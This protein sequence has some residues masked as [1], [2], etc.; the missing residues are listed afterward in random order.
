[1]KKKE[2]SFQDLSKEKLRSKDKG[3][4][5]SETMQLEEIVERDKGAYESTSPSL[6]N[7]VVIDDD[8]DYNNHTL[9]GTALLKS[10]LSASTASA[11]SVVEKMIT[12]TEVTDETLNL[13][14]ILYQPDKEKKDDKELESQGQNG[15]Q[16]N[17]SDVPVDDDDRR[18]VIDISDEEKDGVNDNRL[19]SMPSL[20]ASMNDE[21]AHTRQAMRP[22]SLDITTSASTRPSVRQNFQVQESKLHVILYFISIIDQTQLLSDPSIVTFC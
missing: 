21:N 1:M 18:L 14:K 11:T 20:N 15:Q 12:T 6:V 22:S 5:M 19:K 17:T 9:K 7:S 13:K 8:D 16:A 3:D 4:K 2:D 10:L